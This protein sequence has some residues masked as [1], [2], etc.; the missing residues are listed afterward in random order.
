MTIKT[1]FFQKIILHTGC[2]NL[3]QW[4]IRFLKINKKSRQILVLVHPKAVEK[5]QNEHK[6][7]YPK[8]IV[9]SFIFFSYFFPEKSK[10]AIN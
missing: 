9:R 7:I 8:H 3:P 1:I 6:T 5:M 10:I 2:A 4:Y